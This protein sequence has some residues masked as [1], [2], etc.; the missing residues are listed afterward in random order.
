[1][2]SREAGSE[3]SS[4]RF[5]PGDFI[6]TKV[7]LKSTCANPGGM[8][9][10]GSAGVYPQAARPP[11]GVRIGSTFPPSGDT[12][13]REG[14]APGGSMPDPTDATH[15]EDTTEVRPTP[16]SGRRRRRADAMTPEELAFVRAVDDYKRRHDCPFPT[17]R[18]ILEIL[19]ALG[20]R[21]VTD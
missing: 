3:S 20:Y 1:M 16:S 6:D 5:V 4:S 2:D 11:T 8:G 9:R 14:E 10:F 12:G 17:L 21:K 13:D 15:D 7:S 19:K 18:E